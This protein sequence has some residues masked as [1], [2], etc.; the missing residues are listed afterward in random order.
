MNIEAV[1]IIAGGLATIATSA[2]TDAI[3]KNLLPVAGKTE[4]FYYK[5]GSALIGAVVGM[6]A[7]KYVTESINE[8]MNAATSVAKTIKEKK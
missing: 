8:L 7:G 6:H 5:V 4:M 3:I 2:T 1:K